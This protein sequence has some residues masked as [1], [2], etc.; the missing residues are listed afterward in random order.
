MITAVCGKLA[1]HCQSRPAG[2]LSCADRA[3]GTAMLAYKHLVGQ[4]SMQGTSGATETACRHRAAACTWLRR[5]CTDALHAPPAPPH[6]QNEHNMACNL[7]VC[8]LGAAAM[9]Q[10][11]SDATGALPSFVPNC[12]GGHRQPCCF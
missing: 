8:C 1:V 3:L 5:T 12:V 6:T 11:G 9:M 2:V 10:N 7:L 4:E